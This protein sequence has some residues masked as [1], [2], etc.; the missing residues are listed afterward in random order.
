MAVKKLTSSLLKRLIDEEVS[1]KF[2]DMSSTEDASKETSEVDA[3]ELADTL[4]KHI[5]YAKALK[6]EAARVSKRLRR[7]QEARK[8]ILR[9][10][11][12]HTP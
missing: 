9:R 3:D 2:G 4:E 6:I 11:A 7:I 5:D 12:R 1:K 10:I 8:R